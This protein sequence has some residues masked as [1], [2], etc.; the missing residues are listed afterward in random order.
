MADLYNAL[1]QYEI[2]K[3]H[4]TFGLLKFKKVHINFIQKKLIC[5][6]G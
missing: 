3:D 2:E 1:V 4:S 5:E 6:Y